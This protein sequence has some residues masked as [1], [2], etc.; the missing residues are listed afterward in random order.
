MPDVFIQGELSMRNRL[1]PVEE[2]KIDRKDTKTQILQP[3]EIGKRAAK[4][5]QR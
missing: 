1:T 5:L 3:Q 4:T 2:A